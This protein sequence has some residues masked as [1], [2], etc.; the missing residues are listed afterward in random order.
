[1]SHQG[2]ARWAGADGW[3][4]PQARR[5]TGLWMRWSTEVVSP[6]SGL[7]RFFVGN[8]RR[9]SF[10]ALPWAGLGW[11]FGPHAQRSSLGGLLSTNRPRA[12]DL[13]ELLP[14]TSPGT[15]L[16]NISP[17]TLSADLSRLTYRDKRSPSHSSR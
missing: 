15:S 12:N 10:L 16:R 13:S 9:R 6:A 5:A 1:M 17:G 4:P 2:F 8:P 7:W 14:E 3:N 11:A